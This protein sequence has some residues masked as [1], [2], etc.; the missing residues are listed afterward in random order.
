MRAFFR[1]LGRLIGRHIRALLIFFAA[2]LGIIALIGIGTAFRM[3]D[4]DFCT[5][6]HYMDPYVRQ[7]QA[8]G[9][10]G[11]TCIECHDYSLGDLAVNTVLYATETYS[12]RPKANVH[13]E[14]C[15]ECHETSALSDLQEYRRGIMFSHPAH[16]EKPLR[17]ENLRCTSCHNQIVQFDPEVTPTHMVVNDRSCF[18]CHFKDAGQG[19]AITGCNSCHGMPKTTVEHAGFTF[20]HQPYL[21]AGVECKQCHTNV[22]SGDG[23]VPDTKCF[24]CHI[25]ESRTEYSRE[26]LHRIHVET[27]GIDCFQCHSDLQHGN[28][29]MVSSLEVQCDNCHVRMHNNPKQLYM[30]IGGADTVDVPSQHFLAQVSCTGC[31]TQNTPQGELV[32]HQERKEAQR[33]SCATCHGKDRVPMYDNWVQGGRTIVADY[34]PYVN[35]VKASVAGIGGTQEGRAAVRAA[36]EGL[37]QNYRLVREGH[38]AHNIWYTIYLLN[39]GP[40]KVQEIVRTY[41]KGFTVPDVPA[42][43]KPENACMTFC[44]ARSFPETVSYN[45][46]S[47]PHQMHVTDLELGCASCHSIET[48]GKTQI[49]KEACS[50]CHEDM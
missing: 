37:E 40:K 31:H 18:V 12:M 36:V 30:G 14:A 33:A 1:D 27:E 34:G 22:V 17:G 4:A 24:Q 8:S 2:V 28:F 21:Q 7:W 47:L 48:H 29:G 50:A 38:A 39:S 44:H 42:S 3:K 23:S 11:V 6:C 46:R 26:D 9:H 32:A 20:D 15:L 35:A 49:D 43:I 25:E 45:G 10:N 13:D 5:T 41:R 16:L 19:E